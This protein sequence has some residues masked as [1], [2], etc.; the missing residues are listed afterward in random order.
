MEGLR[1][2]HAHNYGAW[3]F[4]GIARAV[5]L[6]IVPSVSNET[7]KRMKNYF[8]RHLKDKQSGRFGNTLDPSRGYM[9]WLNWGGD[10]GMS[11]AN[12]KLAGAGS[13]RNPTSVKTLRQ[14]EP[15]PSTRSE[16]IIGDRNVLDVHGYT[17]LGE[18]TGGV[19]AGFPGVRWYVTRPGQPEALYDVLYA[20]DVDEAAG[21]VRT[22]LAD[23]DLVGDHFPAGT[24]HRLE[25]QRAAER[26]IVRKSNPVG[27]AALRGVERDM[28]LLPNRGAPRLRLNP[29]PS[30]AEYAAF[31]RMFENP[32]KAFF[33]IS[34]EVKKQGGWDEKT[35]DGT[36]FCILAG[37]YAGTYIF[38]RP[39]VRYTPAFDTRINRHGRARPLYLW[40]QDR[41]NEKLK[42]L[43][44]FILE[45]HPE[46]APSK[47]Q[48]ATLQDKLA[49]AARL[50]DGNFDN[51]DEEYEATQFTPIEVSARVRALEDELEAKQ[52]DPTGLKDITSKAN[53]LAQKI[54]LLSQVGGVDFDSVVAALKEKPKRLLTFM[55]Y[56]PVPARREERARWARALMT[57][58]SEKAALRAWYPRVESV[59]NM[60]RVDVVEP[61]VVRYALANFP[62]WLQVAERLGRAS[63]EEREQMGFP[64]DSSVA[65]LRDSGEA[66][67]LGEAV[68]YKEAGVPAKAFQDLLRRYDH[69]QL[70]LISDTI[71]SARQ[72]Y[73][74]E[75]LAETP[76]GRRVL[77]HIADMDWREVLRDHDFVVAAAQEAYNR[78]IT[79]SGTAGTPDEPALMRFHSRANAFTLPAGVKP[80]TTRAAFAIEGQQM[81]HCVGGYFGQRRSWCFSFIAPDGSRA[82]LELT[83]SGRVAQFYGRGN[84]NPS[85]STRALLKQFLEI[86]KEN[87]EKMKTGAF[88]PKE[89]V[90]MEVNNFPGE[91]A[92]QNPYRRR[93]MSRTQRNPMAYFQV[94]VGHR[95]AIPAGA[96]RDSLLYEGYDGKQAA[97]YASLAD[98][99]GREV[100]V[101]VN[102]QA[103]G[104]Q[105]FLR[106]YRP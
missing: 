41:V 53:G 40:R 100:M 81:G 78:Q 96:E 105:E 77:Q 25:R 12:S 61:A 23:P 44:A 70:R 95:G 91:G 74:A 37:P 68:R 28:L 65:A 18:R 63:R 80:L 71:G 97:Y 86:N 46:L 49:H 43:P 73:T 21:H 84:S 13:K 89:L 103:Q 52:L 31:D 79:A 45:Q 5:E 90:Q 102:G 22:R 76:E 75:V 47:Y 98:K 56:L 3:D 55:D 26:R 32:S 99:M 64:M 33:N 54:Y 42:D 17:H 60:Q 9:A 94:I 15:P 69:A 2:S 38:G 51:V 101:V 67:I 62:S 87:I 30:S 59:T 50:R 29:L 104:V 19:P 35:D 7:K 39:N 66:I 106:N 85:A 88:P 27:Y 92:A 36:L 83:G 48:T 11:W 58:F 24:T 6:S 16:V 20:K 14:I 8:T 72:P 34:N 93:P 10:P 4:I 82:T 1:L 57:T